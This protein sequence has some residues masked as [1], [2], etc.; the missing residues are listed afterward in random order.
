M[1][2]LITSALPYVNN[3][4]HLGNLIGSV[5]S[6][7]VYARYCRSQNY[8]TLYICATD[9]YGTATEIKALEL[10]ST[11]E[12]ICNKFRKIH[13]KVY[14]FF[15]IQFDYFG[16]TPTQAHTKVT[17]SFFL[18]LEKR[19]YIFEKQSTQF[20]CEQDKIFLADRFVEGTCPYCEYQKAKGD[21]CDKCGKLLD[22]ENLID[23]KCKICKNPPIAKQTTH[24][25]FD[26]EKLRPEFQKFFDS[27]SH[28]WSNNT[29]QTIKKLLEEKLQPRP[30][31]RDLKWGVPIPKKNFEQK[32]FYVWF[33]AVL[34]YI[35]ATMEYL[36]ED[37]DT[38]W[39]NEDVQLYQ[40]MAKDNIVFHA[41]LLPTM[42]L[43]NQSKNWTK[44]FQ[45]SS[46]EYLN[47][48]QSKFSKSEKIGVFGDDVINI[49]LPVDVWRFYLLYN[50]PET[51]DT[52]F[53]WERFHQEVNSQLIDNLGNLL[54]RT[55]V[56]LKKNYNKEIAIT[57]EEK[58]KYQPLYQ[59]WI[60]L[61]GETQKEITESLEA[62]KLKHA[63]H[64]IFFLV[65]QGNKVFQ[66]EEPWKK[67][68][69]NPRQVSYLLYLLIGLL[70]DIAIMLS[71]YIPNFASKIFGVLN[72]DE[73]K[74]KWNY[75]GRNDFLQN[76]TIGEP[77][78]LLE[79]LEY[80]KIL[81]YKNTYSNN[82]NSDK[83]KQKI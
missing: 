16:K 34:G 60:K 55:S 24:L 33:D 80:E 36:P 72:I 31:S 14:D 79:K 5:L 6:A 21:Q 63:F 3:I 62:V 82:A 77:Q 4:P 25:Y 40:F 61:F 66:L 49:G 10:N 64:R 43:G 2:K 67:I 68:K 13:K 58:S 12:E 53:D 28:L 15:C 1:K 19:G 9:E 83:E 32:V 30:I 26:L 23:K 22:P 44:L 20:Y 35:S 38:W 69:E 71:P 37:W 45:I 73:Q 27:R 56:F 57:E 78:I 75:I 47:Y 54:N 51:S 41:L 7:D 17:Q 59:D 8:P 11:P 74:L 39:A 18:E 52:N 42:Q 76:H 65:A 70:K 50:R 46:S 48:E 29:Q 81:E